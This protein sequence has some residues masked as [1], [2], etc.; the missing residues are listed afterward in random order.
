MKAETGS[1]GESGNGYP[2]ERDAGFY[3]LLGLDQGY[4]EDLRSSTVSSAVKRP[5]DKSS[6]R[7]PGQPGILTL[8]LVE[9]IALS[10]GFGGSITEIAAGFGI[11]RRRLL[12]WLARGKSERDSIYGGLFLRVTT[13]RATRSGPARLTK[14]LE[15]IIGVRPDEPLELNL[16]TLRGLCACTA[17]VYRKFAPVEGRQHLIELRWP[18]AGRKL[19]VVPEQFVK[20][21]LAGFSAGPR[22]RIPF[23][24]L[25]CRTPSIASEVA[26][27]DRES[28]EEN[29]VSTIS[30]G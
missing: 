10:V 17:V 11:H 29:S 28:G 16:A 20:E 9:D 21:G 6:T 26:Q 25:P 22:R 15:A 12:K 1:S 8:Q 7:G 23:H 30:G 13:A 2:R 27:A 24:C 14:I 3:D 18:K 19:G 4:Q 5:D